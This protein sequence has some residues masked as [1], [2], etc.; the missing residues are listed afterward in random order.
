MVKEA[1]QDDHET[2]LCWG[3]RVREVV[4]KK[5]LA[6]FGGAPWLFSSEVQRG[7]A[8]IYCNVPPPTNTFTR[9][10]RPGKRVTVDAAIFVRSRQKPNQ[11]TPI[12]AA[13]AT[14][15]RFSLLLSVEKTKA[16]HITAET[17]L[18]LTRKISFHDPLQT[19]MLQ[20]LIS[21]R[22]HLH[23]H[24]VIGVDPSQT[25]S[26]NLAATGNVEQEVDMLNDLSP[27]EYLYR[28]KASRPIAL[29]IAPHPPTCVAKAN[30]LLKEAPEAELEFKRPARWIH[31]P[32]ASL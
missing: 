9:P 29:S 18:L 14:K 22:A 11:S 21:I 26:P 13:A 16:S 19:Y 10:P 7:P 25:K 30:K 15:W 6:V 4:R 20:G 3:R 23:D 1:T 8:T 27:T 2:R 17:Q 12:T 31:K 28:S 24:H 5:G 32:V